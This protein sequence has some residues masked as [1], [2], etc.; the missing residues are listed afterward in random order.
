MAQEIFSLKSLNIDS[1]KPLFDQYKNSE[2]YPLEDLAI[3]E[4]P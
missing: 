3:H 2:P 4:F 1:H